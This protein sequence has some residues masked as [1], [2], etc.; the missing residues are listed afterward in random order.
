M[1]VRRISDILGAVG[2]GGTG[3]LWLCSPLAST[4]LPL[5]TFYAAGT[6]L[7]ARQA[8]LPGNERPASP[9][10]ASLSGE[11]PDSFTFSLRSG[12]SRGVIFSLPTVVVYLTALLT[13]ASSTS[14]T[15]PHPPSSFLGFISRSTTVC[16]SPCHRVCYWGTPA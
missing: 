15:V 4:R 10:S 12:L 7:L 13:L 14:L 1:A 2:C 9:Q 5:R 8:A 6:S 16:S 11:V 3:A